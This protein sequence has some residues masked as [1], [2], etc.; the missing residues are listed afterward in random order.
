MRLGL[1]GYPV[2]H[3][4]SP[5]LYRKFLGPELT[6]YE[7]FSC[8]RKEDIPTLE[9][10]RKSFDGLNITSP[11]KEHFVGEI[12]IPSPLVRSLGAVNTLAFVGDK[13]FGSNT[14][15]VAIVE[16]LKNYK[17]DYGDIKILLLGD[18]VMA[19]VT[20]L[21]ADDLG[22]PLIQFSRRMTTNFSNIDLR[23][24]QDNDF[25][26]IIINS[27]SREFVFNGQVSGDEIF[28]DYNYAF[29]PHET[30]LPGMVKLY[31]D[32]QEMLELQAKAAIN[33]WK[34]LNPKL[35]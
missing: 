10:F 14:D 2:K 9:T 19:R 4:R 27:C 16:I 28:W 32:G 13:T 35:K 26:N 15:L 23:K 33:F 24:Y 34:E 3:S 17:R 25:Q 12:E 8:E 21:V 11:Y 6:S 22:I 1:L 30:A 29:S 5:E 7:L 18:G 20:R 31:H